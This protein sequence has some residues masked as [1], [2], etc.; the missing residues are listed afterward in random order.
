MN[1]TIEAIYHSQS[2]AMAGKVLP[3]FHADFELIYVV[4]GWMEVQV[5]GR[6]LRACAPSVVFLGDLELHRIVSVS[7]DYER[8]VL[9]I[10]YTCLHGV[11]PVLLSVFRSRPADFSHVL[12]TED[13]AETLNALFD[14]L[15]AE[16]QK[17]DLH[18]QMCMESLVRLL[19]VQLHRLHPEAFP[20]ARIRYPEG[21]V[22]AQRYLDEHFRETLSVDEVAKLFYMSPSSFRHLFR[23]LIG[24]SPKQYI[25]LSRLSCAAELLSSTAL[26]VTEIAERSGFS[27]VNNFIRR[28]RQHYGV[29]PAAMRKI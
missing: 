19:L 18:S 12:Q 22:Q 5:S 2:S 6:C 27:D 28:F 14:A 15:C 17:A 7:E 9:T 25:T 11:A 13:C 21:I 23:T 16:T 20:A 29:T 1:K 26:S 8:Y 10:P 4:R 3:H 24:L